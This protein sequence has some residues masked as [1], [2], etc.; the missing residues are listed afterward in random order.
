KN[1]THVRQLLGFER[2]GHDLAVPLVGELL[3]AWSLWR[4]AFTTTFKQTESKRV[5]SKTVRR[6]EKT[7]ETPCE[8][9]VEYREALGDKAG[10]AALRAWRELHDPFE[11]KDW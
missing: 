10:A 7:P 6:H 5:G 3:E 9:L 8:R 4:N 2:L 11:L 1:S